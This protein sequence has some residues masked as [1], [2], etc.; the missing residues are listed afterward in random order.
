[1][2]VVHKELIFDRGSIRF[3]LLVVM[4]RPRKTNFCFY[5]W[6]VDYQM[7][8]IEFEHVLQQHSVLKRKL[9]LAT[10]LLFWQFNNLLQ[11]V[12]SMHCPIG[13]IIKKKNIICGFFFSPLLSLIT[14]SLRNVEIIRLVFPFLGT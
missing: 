5:I 12:H 8:V 3:F 2:H 10:S 4:L 13:R 7:K 11:F 9:P 1:M 14:S 6:L